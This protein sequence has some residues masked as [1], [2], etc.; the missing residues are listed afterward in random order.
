[1]P[2]TVK[3]SER[4][5]V[6]IGFDGHGIE[7]KDGAALDL[8]NTDQWELVKTFDDGYGFVGIIQLNNPKLG[9]Y[10][11]VARAPAKDDSINL[12]EVQIYHRPREYTSSDSL[13]YSELTNGIAQ[14]RS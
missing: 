4:I 13:Q 1:M 12:K 11:A 5:E 10:V 8:T 3:R 2:F 9:R 6:F 7:S 14:T